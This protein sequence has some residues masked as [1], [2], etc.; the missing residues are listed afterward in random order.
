MAARPFPDSALIPF[1]LL[2]TTLV[3]AAQALGMR[4][5]VLLAAPS[6]AWLYVGGAYALL[7]VVAL[8][9]L[10]GEEAIGELLRYEA[11]DASRGLLAAGAGLVLLY[12]VSVAGLAL[13]PTLA[14]RDLESLVRAY[15][16]GVPAKWMRFAALS[17]FAIAEE[18]V[19][20]GAVLRAIESKMGSARAPW[21]AGALYVIATIPTLRAPMIGAA[22]LI[23]V[24]TTVLV[25][26][27]GRV[28]PA[29]IAHLMFSWLALDWILPTLW[30]GIR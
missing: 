12:A 22:V 5:S 26:R 13:L 24:L 1:A 16:M 7:A 23:A 8:L 27:S 30:N 10:R 21:I 14:V 19:W 15:L 6:T 9:Y 11:G 4:P 28:T 29:I 18:L 25:R 2:A 20:R 17:G 3:G